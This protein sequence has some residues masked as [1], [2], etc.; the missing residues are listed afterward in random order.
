MTHSA[1]VWKQSMAAFMLH[2]LRPK[3]AF[4]YAF[5]SKR[6]CVHAHFDINAVSKRRFKTHKNVRLRSAF[7][8]NQGFWGSI[9]ANSH[10]NAFIWRHIRLSGSRPWNHARDHQRVLRNMLSRARKKLSINSTPI[11]SVLNQRFKSAFQNAD[12][13]FAK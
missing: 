10:L 13:A 5:S 2:F 12:S 6:G 4:W 7:L 3:S 9:N 8:P 11:N 1:L